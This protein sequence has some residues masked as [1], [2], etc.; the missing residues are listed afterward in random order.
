MTNSTAGHY[1]GWMHGMPHAIKD[2]MPRPRSADVD[3]LAD[4]CR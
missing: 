4:L 2:L 1:R 3:G